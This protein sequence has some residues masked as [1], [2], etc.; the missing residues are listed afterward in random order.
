M[1]KALYKLQLLLLLL[2][3]YKNLHIWFHEE[4]CFEHCPFPHGDRCGVL[5]HHQQY[6]SI[7]V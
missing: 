1:E 7:I 4:S 6:G 2:L 3:D 5:L